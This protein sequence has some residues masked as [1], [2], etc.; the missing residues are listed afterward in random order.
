MPK[1]SPIWNHSCSHEESR[2][3]RFYLLC[4]G[5][6]WQ[7]YNSTPSLRR[8]TA[9]TFIPDISFGR[10]VQQP[11]QKKGKAKGEN[12]RKKHKKISSQEKGKS[13]NE[14]KAGTSKWKILAPEQ[15]KT[16]GRHRVD[17]HC[18]WPWGYRHNRYFIE[19]ALRQWANSTQCLRR[20]RRAA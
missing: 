7:R 11:R 3:P 2:Q 9:C 18:V 1:H 10:W 16:K 19:I 4:T 20:P 13:P 14:K 6:R 8:G 17:A 12:A 15:K 5:R